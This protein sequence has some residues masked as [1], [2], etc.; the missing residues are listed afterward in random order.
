MAFKEMKKRHLGGYRYHTCKKCT[1][2]EQ[3]D[4]PV[5]LEVPYCS[6]CKKSVSDIEQNYCGF[7]GEK[8]ND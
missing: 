4:V 6:E 5:L 7:C 1:Y 8:F 2:Q 3:T